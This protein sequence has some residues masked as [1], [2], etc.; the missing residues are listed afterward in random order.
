MSA[1]A[2]ACAGGEPSR[3]TE[4]AD[5]HR[6]RRLLG[7]DDDKRR[8]AGRAAGQSRERAFAVER[9]E[10]RLCVELDAP[11]RARP[12]MGVPV[13][14]TSGTPANKNGWLGVSADHYRWAV[15][16]V[17]VVTVHRHVLLVAVMT[18]HDQSY[19]A[20]IRRVEQ[21]ARAAVAASQNTPGNVSSPRNA[22]AP[23]KS[24]SWGVSTPV[25]RLVE[26]G[27]LYCLEILTIRRPRQRCCGTGAC[28]AAHG[29]IIP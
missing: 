21:L 12:A 9:G 8:T 18:Q 1:R 17:G 14:A 16:S 5:R 23:V 11:C 13:V 22:V 15:N 26:R 27:E 6:P 28:R 25:G 4:A 10:S 29:I 24:W 2:P 7:P 19:A 3:A 20:G